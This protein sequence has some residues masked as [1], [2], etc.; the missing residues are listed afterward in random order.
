MSVARALA[1]TLCF[2]LDVQVHAETLKCWKQVTPCAVSADHEKVTLES[3]GIKMVLKPGSLIEKTEAGTISIVKGTVLL[4]AGDSATAYRTPFAK[5]W[6][7]DRCV[8]L[9]EREAEQMTIKSLGGN[10]RAQRLGDEQEYAILAGTRVLFTPVTTDGRAG[11]DFAQSLPWEST[12][13]EWAQLYPDGK[14]QFIADVGRFR[15]V[16]SKGVESATDM[17]EAN[18]GRSIAAYDKAQAQ[19]RA[20]RQAQEREDAELR[21]LF[22]EKNY[23]NP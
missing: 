5:L 19:A 20:R 1:L 7:A 23:I 13:K 11:M 9:V 22:R 21:R 14:D 6:C 8:A 18:V 17:Q 10:W 15:E 16:W 3:S 12:V 2:F 4:Q